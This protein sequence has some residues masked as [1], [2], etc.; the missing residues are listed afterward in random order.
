V[1]GAESL[2]PVIEP[3]QHMSQTEMALYYGSVQKYYPNQV[4]AL[5]VYSE[6][7]W[8]AAKTFVQAI[9][10]LGSTPVSRQSL[11]SALNAMKGFTTNLT[12][13]LSYAPGS[14]HDPNRCYQWIRNQ[15]GT[16]ATYSGWNCF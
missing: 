1:Y 16:W 13:P 14:S 5:D 2:T 9:R 3:D 12:V 11:V 6:T 7:E 10:N 4:S 8:V 15:S